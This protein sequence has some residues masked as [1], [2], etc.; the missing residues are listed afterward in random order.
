MDSDIER[1]REIYRD[2]L[3]EMGD[4]IPS[5][6]KEIGPTY[7]HIGHLPLPVPV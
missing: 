6:I 1:N 4:R 7:I 3:L 2:E 5:E